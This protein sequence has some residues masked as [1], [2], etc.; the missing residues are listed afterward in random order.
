MKLT[1]Y[2]RDAF[3]RAAMQD[4]PSIDYMEQARAFLQAESIEQLPPKVRAI[5]KDKN[6][7]HFLNTAGCHVDSVGY[8]SVLCGRGDDFK[9]SAEAREKLSAISADAAKQKKTESELRSKLKAVAYSASTRKQ[10]AE[11]LPEFVKYL[12]ADEATAIRSVPVVANVVTDFVKAGW[13]KGKKPAA[14]AA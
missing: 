2:M 4:V 14:V 8:I 10:L 6:L 11:L 9:P 1:N 7:R 13:P 5:A 3:I 12:P